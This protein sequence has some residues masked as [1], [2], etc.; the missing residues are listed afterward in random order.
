MSDPHANDGLKVTKSTTRCG[1]CLM[2][3]PAPTAQESADL[4][5]AHI[6]AGCLKKRVPVTAE[7]IDEQAELW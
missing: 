6:E 4:A 3:F 7:V 2:P 1:D 5:R